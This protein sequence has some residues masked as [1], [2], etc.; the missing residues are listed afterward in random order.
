MVVFDPLPIRAKIQQFD[1]FVFKGVETGC[2]GKQ[3]CFNTMVHIVTNS[4]SFFIIFFYFYYYCYYFI[5]PFSANTER[6]EHIF[7]L[8]HFILYLFLNLFFFFHW[9]VYI[10]VMDMPDCCSKT[11]IFQCVPV[12][13]LSELFKKNKRRKKQLLHRTSHYHDVIESSENYAWD[14]FQIFKS[15]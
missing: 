10:Y 5:S 9:R 12:C 2:I 7:I 1:Y 15:L 14:F 3:H 8:F 13:W 11:I 6:R 4:L